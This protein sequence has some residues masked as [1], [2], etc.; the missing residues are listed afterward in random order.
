MPEGSERSLHQKSAVVVMGTEKKLRLVATSPA[1]SAGQSSRD[2]QVQM[3]TIEPEIA[4]KG[5]PERIDQ[6][7]R[8]V[9]VH[10][11]LASGHH[12]WVVMMVANCELSLLHQQRPKRPS[13]QRRS[14]EGF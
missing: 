4:T 14:T 3:L 6:G 12:E 11:L 2:Q 10:R 7:A 13:V 9:R 5:C 1:P 8:K